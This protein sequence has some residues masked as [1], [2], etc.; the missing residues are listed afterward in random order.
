MLNP[1]GSPKNTFGY[2]GNGRETLST[3]GATG[4]VAS[5]KYQSDGRILALGQSKGTSNNFQLARINPNG[6]FDSGFG[7]GGY[8]YVD[9]KGH[10]DQPAA[11][12]I[13]PYGKIVLAGSTEANGNSDIA[14]ARVM[15]HV[16]QYSITKYSDG[17]AG[18]K[19]GAFLIHRN[20]SDPYAFDS[21]VLHFTISGTAKLGI[22]YHFSMA[23]PIT[24][25][26]GQTTM[27][28][29]VQTVKNYLPTT[30]RT[31]NIHLKANPAYLVLGGDVS[32]NIAPK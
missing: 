29:E 9:F 10:N 23:M 24:F 4:P 31:V 21:T 16:C 19:N 18:T 13:A 26:P 7:F 27:Y 28:I 1:N 6:T 5:L 12:T 20:A 25:Q 30:L 11:M 17:I 8:T 2:A 15:G 3:G 32:I 14:L 22:D